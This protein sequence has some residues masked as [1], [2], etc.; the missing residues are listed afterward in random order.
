MQNTE[1]DLRNFIIGYSKSIKDYILVLRTNLKPL[2]IISALIFA[3]ALIYSL[4]SPNI[5]KSTV[6]L[7]LIKQQESILKPSNSNMGTYD[8]DRLIANEIDVMENY[9]TREKVA[10]ALVDSIKNLKDKDSFPLLTTVNY[11]DY[12]KHQLI[13]KIAEILKDHIKAEQ[14]EGMDIVE[15]S[16]ESGSSNEAALIANTYAGEYIKLNLEENRN[17]LTTVRKFLEKRREEKSVELKDAEKKLADFQQKGGIVALDAQSTALISQLSQLDAQ[18]D[19][20]KIDLM[21]SN[22]ILNQYK[23]D[24]N[25]EDPHLANYL[26]SQTSQ[27]YIDVL[28]KQIA[29]L[30]MNRDMAT[31]NKSS[32]LD[33]S[34][35][36]KDYDKRINNLKDK[37]AEKI[38]EIKTGAFSTSPDQI[39]ELTRKLIEEG[40]RNHSLAIKLDELQSMTNNYNVKLNRL[41]QKSMEYAGYE[42]NMQALQQLYSLVEQ[43]YQEAVINELSQP[44][45]I[46]IIA[47]GRIPEKPEKP[48]RILIILSGLIGGILIGVFYVLIKDYFDD[49]IKTP[50]DIG[51]KDLNLLTW[52]PK[53]KTDHAASGYRMIVIDEPSSPAAE[54]F[55]V[56]RARIQISACQGK[57]SQV[58]LISSALAGEG[59]TMTATN[60]AFNLAQIKKKTLL[61][62]GDLRRPKIHK[63]MET[64]KVP[65]LVDIIT[66]K[67]YLQDVLRKTKLEYLEFICSGRSEAD[68]KEIYETVNYRG[69]QEVF[70]KYICSGIIDADPTE[71]FAS[72][73]MEN[74][75]NEMRS[76]FDFIIIDSAPLISVIDSE[77][78]SKYVDHLV[79][80]VSSEVTEKRVLNEVLKL[81]KRIN[82]PLLGIVL[83]NFK[84][85]SGYDYYFNNYYNYSKEDHVN[86]NHK[87]EKRHRS[88][89]NPVNARSNE[90]MNLK[91]T[92]GTAIS[93]K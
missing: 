43:K 77:I 89:D 47:E 53:F 11:D 14:K 74:F 3:A 13:N 29:E 23:E 79:L 55:K 49:T 41:P 68:S 44:G 42:R 54:A 88:T 7:K 60:L 25:N 69:F 10:K 83:N 27:A 76:H 64:N 21:T 33:V 65:G 26:E 32:S 24:I 59:K 58:I 48:N 22:A 80:V 93:R 5:Y 1:F 63:I 72:R 37:L 87:K 20:A 16:A 82:I 66:Q 57:T 17:Q 40:I 92:D 75:L 2:F 50:E 18:R 34:E 62:D 4:I 85:K 51:K 12:N 71:L 61:I 8:L 73:E 67:V 56:L 45:N 28:Q 9:G 90:K 39:K 86:V 78:L 84:H 15:I 81:I 52:I 46:F 30:Q 6:T 19:A 35:K 91:E 31:A 36:V 70:P 38:E